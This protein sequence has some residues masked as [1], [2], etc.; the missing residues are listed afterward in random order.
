MNLNTTEGS[1]SV[2][3]LK[4]NSLLD[5]LCNILLNSAKSTFGTSEYSKVKHIGEKK[6]GKLKKDWSTIVTLR[7]E[8]LENVRKYSK[9]VEIMKIS[10]TSN[11]QKKDIKK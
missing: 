7:E 4:I 5:N 3:K 9:K 1:S 2:D 8:T 6:L 11:Q 10:T